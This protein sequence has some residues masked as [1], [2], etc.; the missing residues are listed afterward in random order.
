MRGKSHSVTFVRP[1]EAA[2][3]MRTEVLDKSRGSVQHADVLL[4]GNYQKE[5]VMPKTWHCHMLRTKA[6]LA[7]GTLNT[8]QIYKYNGLIR[9]L[10]CRE[11]HI[12]A[13]SCFLF[14]Y[15]QS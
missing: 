10:G 2:I 4:S 13:G 1:I 15:S 14:I 12:S 8:L 3:K 7:A 5:V 6:Q 9:A 11:I